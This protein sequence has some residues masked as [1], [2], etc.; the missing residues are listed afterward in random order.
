M[1]Q[2]VPLW[3]TQDASNPSVS[4]PWALNSKA[5]TPQPASD[6]PG[7]QVDID[8]DPH[9]DLGSLEA[10]GLKAEG[11]GVHVFWFRFRV[12]S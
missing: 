3:F 4:R 5:L 9:G 8:L 6:S 7:S 1:T 11:F 10:A 2:V 12:S